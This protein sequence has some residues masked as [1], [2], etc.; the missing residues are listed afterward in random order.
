MVSRTGSHPIDRGHGLGP[1]LV[2]SMIAHFTR[3]T[4]VLL[5]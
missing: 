5:P 3:T 4:E 1:V 2:P